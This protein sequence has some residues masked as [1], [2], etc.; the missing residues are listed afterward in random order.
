[1]SECIL[2][3]GCK[4]KDGYGYSKYK[5][6]TVKAHRLV[7]A[8]AHMLDVFT[9]GGVVMHSCDNPSCINIDHLSIGT[10]R[11]NTLDMVNKGRWLGN[12]KL[13]RED[14]IYIHS[15]YVK[16]HRYKPGNCLE[17]AA[18]FGISDVQVRNIARGRHVYT[19]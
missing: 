4:D 8:I 15:H 18:R 9:M 11:D 12:C 13:S 6:R 16:G 1:M 10:S 5:R 17:L 3:V 19:Q 7:Y 2:H 14:V